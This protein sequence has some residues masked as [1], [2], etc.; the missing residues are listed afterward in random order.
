MMVVLV[1]I[2]A[3]TL[4]FGVSYASTRRLQAAS[5]AAALAAANVFADKT[6]SC[7]TI[8]A[9]PAWTA[10]AASAASA[11]REDN[12]PGS[13][14]ASY[15]ATCTTKGSIQVR[16]VSGGS[17]P[18]LLGGIFGHNGPYSATRPVTAIASEGAETM[19]VAGASCPRCCPPRSSR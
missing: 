1:G 11:I 13:T 4:D 15:S 17:T 5:D 7:A 18:T 6:G 12:R 2:G 14:E 10:A 19:A 9:T 3:F 8:L 16:Y